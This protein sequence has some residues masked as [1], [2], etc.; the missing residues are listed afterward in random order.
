LPR[1]ESLLTL[2]QANLARFSLLVKCWWVEWLSCSQK[3]SHLTD[4]EGWM[5]WSPMRTG[6]LHLG[7]LSLG[8]RQ[9]MR[10]VLGTENVRLRALALL[11]ATLYMRWR[12]RTF[13]R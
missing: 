3:P 13:V 8:V 4:L 11:E 12:M 7:D 5:S 6:R 1:S 9:W 2:T 10:S